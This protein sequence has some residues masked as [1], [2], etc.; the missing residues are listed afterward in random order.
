LIICEIGLNHLGD[1]EYAHEYI[2]KILST[3]IDAITFQVRE[4]DFYVNN[5][6]DFILSD[7]FYRDIF[8]K[9]KNSNVKFGIALSDVKKIPFFN[10]LN[11]DFFKVLSKDFK[12]DKLI[13]EMLKTKK[14]IFVSTGI[15]SEIEISNFLKTF[16]SKKSF[17][18]LI[19]TQM[20]HNIED[21]NLK[22]I[23]ILQK[24]FQL[25]VAY[26]NHSKYSLVTFVALGFEP[27]DIF[28][29][30]K[31]NRSKSHP[32]EIH[33]IPLENIETFVYDL[34]EMKKSI[35]SGLKKTIVNTITD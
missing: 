15:V 20:T 7:D 31:G 32:D 26:G 19:H 35:G 28:I 12:N 27:S 11:I 18:T 29:Y 34:R 9:I 1:E 4:P 5:Y 10:T 3:N 2:S 14:H 17:F 13:L 30:V 21:V 25:P 24:K 33:S 23:S 22:A 8:N 6:A 16:S